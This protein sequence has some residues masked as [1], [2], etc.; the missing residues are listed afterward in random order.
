MQTK[1]ETVSYYPHHWALLPVLR[2]PGSAAPAAR[3]GVDDI[4]ALG[5]VTSP[6]MISCI[7]ASSAST[8]FDICITVG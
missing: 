4:D 6:L 5:V 3:S 8:L 1:T 7:A 2:I